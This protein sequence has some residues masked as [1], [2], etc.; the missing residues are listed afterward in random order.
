MLGW[1]EVKLWQWEGCVKNDYLYHGKEM[2]AIRNEMTKSPN[3]I[4]NELSL[5]MLFFL[6]FNKN[7]TF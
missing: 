5:S 1:G 3:E 4:G 6:I 2:Q 7:T